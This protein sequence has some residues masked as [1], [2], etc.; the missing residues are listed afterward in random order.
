MTAGAAAPL[1]DPSALR[2]RLQGTP[3]VV[4]LDVDGTLAP[5]APRPDEATVPESTRRILNA[6][7]STPGVHLG[8]I[9]GRGAADARRLVG[10]T[11]AW[12]VG[13]HG[14]ET[15]DPDGTVTIDPLCEPWQP[16]V[17][18]AYE[19][20][21]RE[22]AGVRN[23]IVEDKTLTL[24]IHY[25]LVDRAEVPALEECVRMV[26]AREGLRITEGREIR[27]VRPP[28]AVHKG[29]AV[30]ALARR[31]GA[32]APHASR[33]FAGDDVTDEDAMRALREAHPDSVTIRVHG[34]ANSTT[35]AEFAV[36]GTEEL[37]GWLEKLTGGRRSA[38][39]GS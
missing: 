6:L 12:I 24:S 5:I 22:L 28:V 11:R 37:A 3:L 27:E 30:L 1:P 32:D 35:D 16:A 2:S 33:L 4:L 17:R 7:A 31:L 10:D 13:N 23:A 36:E 9:T 38:V 15:V 21:R 39:G 34:S 19:A 25:R 26:G 18:R 14:L 20:L 29:T 8:F